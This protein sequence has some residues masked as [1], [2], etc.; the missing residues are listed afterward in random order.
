MKDFWLSCGHHLLDRGEGGG[1]VVTDEFLKAYL[2]RPG[3]GDRGL[4]NAP[5]PRPLPR[6]R[7]E[8]HVG[9]N[10][11]GCRIAGPRPIRNA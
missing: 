3:R 11:F 9:G 8:C 2:A 10:R 4:R 1:L 6:S 5:R 7:A